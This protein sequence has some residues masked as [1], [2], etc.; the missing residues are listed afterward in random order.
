M[1]RGIDSKDAG[2]GPDI[3]TCEKT[4]N[5]HKGFAAGIKA[6]N[7]VGE[8]NG[9]HAIPASRDLTDDSRHLSEQAGAWI[10]AKDLIGTVH[11]PHIIHAHGDL[12]QGAR[13]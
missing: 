11:S 13:N 7:I 9:P 4:A 10:V 2:S 6:K 5:L 12:G 3:D 8:V 1:I